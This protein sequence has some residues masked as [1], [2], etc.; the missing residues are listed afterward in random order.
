MFRKPSPFAVSAAIA[1]AM[2]LAATPAFAVDLPRA[3]GTASAGVVDGMASY[4]TVNH[5]RRHRSDGIDAGDVL[6]GILVIGGIA[7]IASAVSSSSK[8]NRD[9]D[10]RYP[11]SSGGDYR[12]PAPRGDYRYNDTRPDYNDRDRNQG[13]N[14]YGGG[15]GMD[16]AV[17]MC[18]DQVERGQDR[19]ANVDDSSRTANGW[20]VSGR[21]QNGAGFNCWID[22]AGRIRNIDI[23]AGGS[24]SYQGA[25]AP[26]EDRQYSDDY[27]ARARSE[28]DYG[29]YQSN[30]YSNDGYAIDGDLRGG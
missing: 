11:Q 19:V 4:E 30:D 13:S 15:S 10:Y 25:Y 16:N 27:Y 14:A 12:N 5:R 1:A 21:L 9:S 23:G 26:A 8:S 3:G 29:A 20:Q 2:S 22:N 28:L 17:D 18:V 7:A 6:T 24:S